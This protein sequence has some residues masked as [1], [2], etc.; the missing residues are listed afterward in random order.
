M[1]SPVGKKI[2]SEFRA[3]KIFGKIPERHEGFGGYVLSFGG[4]ILI[5]K[6]SVYKTFAEK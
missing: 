4:K 1:R 5:S 6:K 2:K 3:D